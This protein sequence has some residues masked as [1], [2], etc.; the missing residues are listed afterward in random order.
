MN[1]TDWGWST[2]WLDQQNAL[3]AEW[4]SPG[5]VIR[6]ERGQ[7]ILTTEMGELPAKTR[8]MAA[9]GDWGLWRPTGG[10]PIVDHLLPRKTCISRKGAG[11]SST[12]QI[13]AANVDYV[14]VVS[15][16]NRDLN[17]NRIE[18]Y[19]TMVA[20]G[21]AKPVIVLTKA[22]L[23]PDPQAA[24]EE[25]NGWANHPPIHVISSLTGSGLEALN[26]YMG[27]GQTV[28]LTGSSGTGKSTLINTLL[29]QDSL[30]TG[31][32]READQRGRHTTT[33]REM[34]QLPN[35]GLIID[36]PGIR[37]LSPW[38]DEEALGQT[39]SEI[40]ELAKHCR[41]RD[42]GHQG[43]PGCAVLQAVENGQLEERRLENWRKMAK[44]LRHL[45]LRED[46]NALRKEKQRVKT[47]HKSFRHV[48]AF[49]KRN[50][51]S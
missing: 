41:F 34:L 6:V 47:L 21:G 38:V 39:F 46:E 42:C 45:H 13:L 19:L 7:V 4:M 29:G 24:I 43:E 10:V 51:Q 8:E 25:I 27:P 35:G 31:A 22:D 30:E 33:R 16:L 14:F 2:Y 40:D 32:I 50:R 26:P 44:E 37:E 23:C 36:T 1:L 11:R 17:P 12:E 18:R 15:S 28:V 3:D 49:K 5:R 48:K 9:V 20:G